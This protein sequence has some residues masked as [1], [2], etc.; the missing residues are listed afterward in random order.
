MTREV[1]ISVMNMTILMV[2]ML[3]AMAMMIVMAMV[4][5]VMRM[6]MIEKRKRSWEGNILR[7]RWMTR[8]VV[9]SV[10][11]MTMLLAWMTSRLCCH[12]KLSQ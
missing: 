4:M 11:K 7:G 6:M 2:M 12:S 9:I 10:M 5:V 1:V 3:V 8:V